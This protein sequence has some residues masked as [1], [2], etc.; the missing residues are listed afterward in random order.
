[1]GSSLPIFLQNDKPIES[2]L[3]N[4]FDSAPFPPHSLVKAANENQ[5]LAEESKEQYEE[6]TIE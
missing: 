5:L 4:N 2:N 6:L 1:L 3:R